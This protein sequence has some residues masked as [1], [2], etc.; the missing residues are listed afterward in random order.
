LTKPAAVAGLTASDLVKSL[1]YPAAWTLRARQISSAGH[2][3]AH[4][5]GTYE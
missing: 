2:R 5:T 4:S 3:R 1:T